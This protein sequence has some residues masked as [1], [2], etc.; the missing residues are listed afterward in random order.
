[1]KLQGVRVIDL[2]N[3]LPGPYMTLA[4][5]DHGAEVVKIEQPGGDPGRLI[6]PFDG[7][8]AVFFRNLN[9]GKKS[10]V[11]NLKNAAD[12]E[13][14]YAFSDSA[15]VVV[16]SFRPGVAKRLGV[17]HQTLA[18]RNKR[19]V[20]CSISS[21][22]QWGPNSG[23]PAHDLAV[24]ASSGVL[25]LNL[26]NDGKPCL[27]AIPISDIAAGLS[28]LAGVLMALYARERTGQGDF[29]DISMQEALI[30]AS[31][32]VLG[33]ALA[34]ER[35]PIVKEQRTLGG[36][37][38]YN[39]YETAD[40]RQIAIGGQEE[41]FVRALLGKLGRMDLA[42]L[43]ERGP[44]V[45]QQPVIDLLRNTFGA[46]SRAEAIDL[47]TGLNIGWGP[48]NNLVEALADPHLIE[49]KAILRDEQGKRHIASPIRFA[50]EPARINFHV[51]TLNEYAALNQVK[52]T[53]D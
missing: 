33:T 50:D 14:F 30:A 3:F 5:A 37:A 31:L 20:Y 9:R 1:M 52:N 13:Q 19:L 24:Q 44:G 4:M 10:V 16:E 8:H 48:V 42:S 17:D 22:G 49:R 39:I 46:L 38:F 21:F 53:G 27:P 6:P 51:P 43:C 36:A 45:H 41:K 34:E 29:I 2:S 18:S 15:D 35:N 32:N 12:R 28:G 26:D 40:G 7:E 23:R 47:L 25:S 11:L